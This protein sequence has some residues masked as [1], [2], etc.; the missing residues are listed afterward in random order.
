MLLEKLLL[1]IYLDKKCVS[2][3]THETVH[4]FV[5]VELETEID[6]EGNLVL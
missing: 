4:P 2:Y 6:I 3:L 5:T 1:A